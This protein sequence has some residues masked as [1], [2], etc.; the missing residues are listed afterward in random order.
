MGARFPY[1]PKKALKFIKF[2]LRNKIN[3][4]IDII[5]ERHH[6]FIKEDIKKVNFPE[7]IKIFPLKPSEISKNLANY[8]CG[9]VFIET[10]D[11]IKMS[12]PTKIGEYLAAGLHVLGLEGIEV[13]NRLSQETRSVDT[14]PRDFNYLSKDISRVKKIL[15][16]IK[17][18]TE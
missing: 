7:K 2:L 13:L 4:T 6:K 12:S 8:D 15:E 9:L 14:L 16:N 11:W 3:C 10:G 18:L 1:L 5:N 17:T